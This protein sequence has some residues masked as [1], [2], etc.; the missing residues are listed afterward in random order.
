MERMLQWGLSWLQEARQKH[1]TSE[2]QVGLTLGEAVP[3]LA[4]ISGVDASNSQQ[5][6]GMQGQYF[7]FIFRK[8]DLETNDIRIR[9]GL[10]IWDEHTNQYDVVVP[11]RMQPEY[12]DPLQLDIAITAVLIAPTTVFPTPLAPS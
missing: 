7:I 5:R 9:R 10:K 11:D 4:T 8:S 2:V 6:V 3:L 1:I 12:N